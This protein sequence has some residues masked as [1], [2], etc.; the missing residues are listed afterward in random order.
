MCSLP[1]PW[2]HA[3]ALHIAHDLGTLTNYSG[4]CWRRS[5]QLFCKVS[6]F[7]FWVLINLSSRWLFTS[8]TFGAKSR[9]QERWAVAGGDC[10]CQSLSTPYGVRSWRF[11]ISC[12]L[13]ASPPHCEHKNDPPVFAFLFWSFIGFI[14]LLPF[15][16]GALRQR[17]RE[18]AGLPWRARRILLT[19]LPS[20]SRPSRL[21]HSYHPYQRT[22][23]FGTSEMCLIVYSRLRLGNFTNSYHPEIRTSRDRI[24]EVS[25]QL[26]NRKV[27]R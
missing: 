3:E 25:L 1:F 16:C 27:V 23:A 20:A 4:Q 2:V 7:S 21:T 5:D 19:T 14:S 18:L 17:K 10:Q 11:V 8:W 24:T 15:I 22:G 6:A 12:L 13:L 26:H 9:E